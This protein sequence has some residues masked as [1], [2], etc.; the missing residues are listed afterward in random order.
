MPQK[1]KASSLPD[2]C[3]NRAVFSPYVSGTDFFP[4]GREGYCVFLMVENGLTQKIEFLCFDFWFI[5]LA[6]Q[7]MRPVLFCTA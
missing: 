4:Q 6:L 3:Q 1:E 5:G 2:P 7:L